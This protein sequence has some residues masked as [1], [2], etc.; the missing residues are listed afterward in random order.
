[1]V[2]IGTTNPLGILFIKAGTNRNFN[3]DTG[4]GSGAAD[5]RI[6]ALNDAANA[7]VDLQIQAAN[8]LFNSNGSERVRITSNG[9]VGIGI[10][11]PAVTLSVAGTVNYTGT[12]QQN[13]SNVIQ[14]VEITPAI[15][16]FSW[17]GSVTSSA[18]T[19]P[20]AVS[21][22]ARYVLADVFV[23]A[24]TTDH[25]SIV[26]G[27]DVLTDQKNWVDT[28]G[29]QPSTQFGTL[30]RQAVT[31]SYFGES[32]G[33]S[34]NYGIWYSSQHIPTTGRTFYFNN[35]GNSGSNGWVYIV[36]KAYS[37]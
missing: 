9:L 5:L 6:S 16:E 26:L 27:R 1:L 25:Q 10:T 28:R 21:T 12:L 18:K 33:F 14:W 3:F 24:S 23:T 4:G 36:V 11:N 22:S 8:T 19:L 30:T 37:L 29:T 2:G 15:L 35:Y 13:G 32:D 31:L 34:S 7:N 17:T 20:S